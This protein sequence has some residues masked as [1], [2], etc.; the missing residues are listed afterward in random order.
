[1]KPENARRLAWGL[2]AASFALIA[3]TLLFRTLTPLGPHETG[4]PLEA[5]FYDAI[6]IAFP[7]VGVVIA[8]RHPRNAVGWIFL[9][10]GF[11]F[12]F[13]GFATRYGIYALF[14]N[15][16]SLPAGPTAA[17]LSVWVLGPA[18]YSFA[19]MLLLFPDGRLPSR[20]WRWAVR[21]VVVGA[22]AF[23][24]GNAFMPGRMPD[25]FESISNPYG[26][27]AARAFVSVLQGIG[28]ALWALSA[29]VGALSLIFRYRRSTK[30][31]RQQLKWFASVGVL[32]ALAFLLIGFSEGPTWNLEL[33]RRIAEV[34]L[35]VAIPA[36]P[37]AA[38]VAILK[39]R[40]Y[41]I[42][43]VINKTVV[44][45]ALAVFITAVYLGL[46]AGIGA[47]IGSRGN[48]L[49][50]ILATAL[51]ALAFQPMRERVQRFA[52]KLVYGERLSPYDAMAELSHQMAGAI[53]LD[54]VLPRL[55]RTAAD[56]VGAARGR[57]RVFL[58]DGEER[59]AWWPA[60]EAVDLFDRRVPVIYQQEEIGEIAVA[61]PPGESLTG[62]EEKLLS[63]LA[64]QAGLALRNVRLTEDL[65]ASRR[66]IVNAQDEERKRMERDIHDGAQQQ[67]VSL[68]VKLSLAESLFEKDPSR[69]VE[70]LRSLRTEVNDVVESVRDLARG[71]YPPLLSEAGVAA[72]LKADVNKLGIDAEI[73]AAD[74]NLRFEPQVEAAMYF[75]IREALQNASKHAAGRATVDL[76][77]HDG[78]VGFSVTD[79]GPGFDTAN[80][81]RG[82]GL[83]NMID[84]LEAVGGTLDI[85]SAPGE[86]T[87]V[88]GLVPTRVPSDV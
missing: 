46:V 1:V 44:Y 10:G 39:Y 31:Q 41:D 86:G 52:N 2:L 61:K 65:R 45:G 66:R 9:G 83:Q 64:S 70:V 20:R 17:W 12:A 26:L 76:W 60:D 72:A 57:V 23:A 88:S 56:G 4:S 16:G 84:R 3:G 30:E 62:A 69:S 6:F 27:E 33:L 73:K 63:D 82:A 22:V 71:I 78:T 51:I 7:L 59:A 55:A 29:V 47:L 48:L 58:P 74:G 35:V 77:F 43:I 13:Q 85:R 8:S 49:L 34:L 42:D 28:W 54:E 68:A 32:L 36:L 75:C 80:A 21:L 14:T 25:A 38:G 87:I 37:V 19:L 15:R 79:R 5:G 53:S 67:L 11:T 50:S 18:I 40:L 81:G 24:L